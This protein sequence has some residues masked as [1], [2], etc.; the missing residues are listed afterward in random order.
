MKV[1]PGDIARVKDGEI[2]PCRD[3]QGLRSMHE[4]DDNNPQHTL[5]VLGTACRWSVRC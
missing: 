1:C 4:S 3:R 2:Q 5:Y